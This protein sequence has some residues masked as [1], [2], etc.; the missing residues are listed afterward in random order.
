M[1]RASLT[2]RLV[3]EAEALVIERALKSAPVA[4]VPP[5]LL[6]SVRSLRVVSRCGCGCASVDFSPP[7]SNEAVWEPL[8]D[9]TGK[10]PTGEDLG[11]IVWGKDGCISGLEIYSYTD[12][13]APLPVIESIVPCPGGGDAA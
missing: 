2:P 6:T 9:A 5:L 10:S 7:T 3:A 12:A 11:I 8:A 13:P 4:E 1:A